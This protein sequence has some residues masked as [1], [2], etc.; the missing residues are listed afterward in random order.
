[1]RTERKILRQQIAARL[2]L[3]R[4]V[5]FTNASDMAR[6]LGLTPQSWF[7]YETGRRQ[8]DAFVA[9]LVVRTYNIDFN[10]LYGG[11]ATTLAKAVAKDL[12]AQ[13]TKPRRKKKPRKPRRRP[14]QFQVERNR[15]SGADTPD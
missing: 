3:L 14:N 9:T 15:S 13:S 11:T 8:L 5:H 7:N 6:S 1:M 10:W 4:E 2:L 12:L